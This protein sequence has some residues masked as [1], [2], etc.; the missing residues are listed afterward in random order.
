M[1]V[2]DKDL[3]VSHTYMQGFA[4]KDLNPSHSYKHGSSENGNCSWVFA[5]DM[6]Y[7]YWPTNVGWVGPLV[8]EDENTPLDDAWY[9]SSPS[10]VPWI[11]CGTRGASWYWEPLLDLKTDVRWGYMA[12]QIAK[13]VGKFGTTKVANT[14]ATNPHNNPLPL[15][16]S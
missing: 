1:F 13:C 8:N 4:D 5:A 7:N 12:D 3:A 14:L 16:C 10:P 11:G 2:A 6:F 15:D 9:V